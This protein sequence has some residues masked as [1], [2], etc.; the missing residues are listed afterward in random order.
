[1][2]VSQ[3]NYLKNEAKNIILDIQEQNEIHNIKKTFKLTSGNYYY[4]YEKADNE[5]YMSLIAPEEWENI[6]DI[7][8][9][10]YYYDFDKQFIFQKK[11]NK[12]NFL[13]S[14]QQ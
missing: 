4:I 3:I 9:G 5:K 14:I 11:I 13:Y 8:I 7:F 12:E 6:Y 10:K 1:M 2:I